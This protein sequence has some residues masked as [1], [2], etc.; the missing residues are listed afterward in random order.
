MDLQGSNSEDLRRLRLLRQYQGPLRV[1]VAPERTI[2]TPNGTVIR[3]SQNLRTG[4]MVGSNP[5]TAIDVS[6]LMGG[7][8]PKLQNRSLFERFGDKFEANSPQD[9]FTRVKRGDTA[10]YKGPKFWQQARDLAVASAREIPRTAETAYRSVIN[11]GYARAADAL[12]KAIS[13][14]DLS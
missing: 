5:K 3:R 14:K 7:P 11:A 9:I 10:E 8:D 1:T 4:P 12:D 13:E 2:T 6:K